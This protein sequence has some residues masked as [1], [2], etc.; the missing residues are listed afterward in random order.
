MEK[1]EIQRNLSKGVVREG[2]VRTITVAA[3]VVQDWLSDAEEKES[4][5]QPAGKEHDKPSGMSVFGSVVG[6]SKLDV[7]ESSMTEISSYG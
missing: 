1:D 7:S 2:W 3:R 6:T 4:Y 5:A